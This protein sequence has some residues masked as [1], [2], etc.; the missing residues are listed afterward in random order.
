ADEDR[1]RV[2]LHP[3][4]REQRGWHVG[5][6]GCELRW[7]LR[8]LALDGADRLRIG[9]AAQHLREA[10]ERGVALEER[11]V[12]EAAVALGIRDR[13]R[14]RRNAPVLV[15]DRVHELV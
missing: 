9:P 13:V 15:L 6:A 12:R 10:R 14:V 3:E 11:A 5:V 4:R 1:A 7:E 2:V 8:E